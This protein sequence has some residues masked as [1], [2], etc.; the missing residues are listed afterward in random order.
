[1]VSDGWHMFKFVNVFSFS[2][3]ISVNLSNNLICV[4][5]IALGLYTFIGTVFEIAY[6]FIWGAE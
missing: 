5:L 2:L 6:N 4:F 1:M 3:A